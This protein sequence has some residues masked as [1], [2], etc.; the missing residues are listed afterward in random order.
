MLPEDAAE[1]FLVCISPIDWDDAW[2]GPQ[3]ISS[4]FAAAGWQVLFVENLGSRPPRF[5][6]HDAKRI[7][8]RLKRLAIKSRLKTPL[9][10]GVQV[11]TPITLPALRSSWVRHASRSILAWQIKR[12]I[13]KR[14][15]THPVVWTYNPSVTAQDVCHALNPSVLVYCCVHDFANLSPQHAHLAGEEEHLMDTA[16]LVFILSNKLFSQRRKGRANV[17]PLPQSANLQHYFDTVPD[18]TELATLPRPIIGYIGSIHEWVD[19]E[20][21][22]RAALAKPGWTFVLIGPER[23]STA[24]L[25]KLSNVVLLGPKTHSEL[26]AYVSDFTVG[27]IPY[28][29][30]AFS[31][32]IRPNKVLEYL[33]MGKPVVATRLPE[34]DALRDHLFSCDSTQQFID[35]LEAAISTDS[36]AQGMHR[37]EVALAN[38]MDREFPQIEYLVL[39]KLC[40]SL[41]SK[42]ESVA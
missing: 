8:R 41:A 35:A 15:A 24:E 27:M 2:E 13:A 39:E 6:W 4:R 40:Q 19:Q 18:K 11:H 16:D 29:T 28:V 10:D 36:P 26:P 12:V 32:T 5:A 37:R 17:Y 22:H 31:E 42:P 14:R 25:R 34:L 38:S 30:N 21:L 9:P 20:L 7:A 33:A 23:V 1:R 3:E